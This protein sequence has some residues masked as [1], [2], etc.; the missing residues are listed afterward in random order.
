[1]TKTMLE[2]SQ[3]IRSAGA[4]L[5]SGSL[6]NKTFLDKTDERTRNEILD[7][8]AKHYGITKQQAYDEVTDADAEHLLEYLTGSVRSAVSVLMQKMGLK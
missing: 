2:Q 7:S 5:A 6:K 1:M 3:A 4:R 8:I